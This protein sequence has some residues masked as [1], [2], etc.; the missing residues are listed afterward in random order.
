MQ[1]VT[2]ADG[3]TDTAALNLGTGVFTI[4]DD[5]PDAVVVNATAAAIVLDESA[6]CARTATATAGLRPGNFAGNFAARRTSAPT[7]W[8]RDLFAGADRS[9]VASGLFALD[10]ADTEP[11]TRRHRP[12]R[13]DRAQPG[14]QR[15]HRLGRRTN[16]FTITLNPATGE[17]TFTAARNNLWHA[18][19]GNHDDPQTLTLANADAAAAGA[20]GDGRRRRQRTRRRSIWAPAC[21][22]IQDD[23]PDA[24]VA[25]AAAAAIV[26]DETRRLATETATAIASATGELRACNFA[27][28]GAGLRH[29][30]PGSATYSLVLTGRTWRPGCLRWMRP[31]PSA[32]DSTASARAR[33]SCSTR[34]ATSSPARSARTNYFTISIN[35]ATGEVTFTAAQQHLARQHRQRRRH[36]RR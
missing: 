18:N 8:Q 6:G 15:H 21:S 35:P 3:D 2:D 27:A 28:A 14:R 19:T 29:R 22:Q 33:R 23:G 7:G 26:L 32:A 31:T 9:N 30:R 34:P 13:A 36:R 11:A 20:D 25:N 17:V 4:Q 12:G 16:Y 24:V 5:G 10:A 1:T